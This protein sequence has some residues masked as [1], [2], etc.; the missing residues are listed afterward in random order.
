MG[1]GDVVLSDRRAAD[2][3]QHGEARL[4]SRAAAPCK[5]HRPPRAPCTPPAPQPAVQRRAVGV[6]CAAL[7]TDSPRQPRGAAL[8]QLKQFLTKVQYLICGFYIIE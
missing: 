2:A 3:L 5:Q 6:A 4:S 1:N 7:F 8:L